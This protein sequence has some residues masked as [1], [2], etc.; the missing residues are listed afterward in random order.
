MGLELED[1]DGGQKSCPGV[2]ERS[3]V[4]IDQRPQM[5]ET[6]GRRHTLDEHLE[7]LGPLLVLLL[8]LVVGNQSGDHVGDRGLVDDLGGEQPFQSGHRFRAH[9]LH[10]DRF[11]VGGPGPI[12]IHQRGLV[13][14]GQPEDRGQGIGAQPIVDLLADDL[15]HRPHVAGGLRDPG[16]RPERLGVAGIVLENVAQRARGSDEVLELLLLGAS[17][18]EA[19]LGLLAAVLEPGLAP[20]PDLDQ[21]GPF[22]ALFQDAG[23]RAFGLLVVGQDRQDLLRAASRLLDPAEAGDVHPQQPA[24]HVHLLLLVRDPGRQ[25]SGQELGVGRPL[26]RVA[27]QPLEIA[28]HPEIARGQGV[29]P[30]APLERHRA[31]AQ[32]FLADHARVGEQ[33]K[34]FWHGERRQV[35]VDGS[36]CRAD[37][38]APIS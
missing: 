28:G 10:V 11:E 32:L 34:T 31:R 14:L 26:V 7:C 37:S 36:S 27:C 22:L 33:A 18:P 9:R 23:Q 8:E 12:G 30:G 24:Q 15:G 35:R 3:G 21:S 25:T 19:Q 13:Q 20:A 5:T 1:A 4:Q 29:R 38:P 16:Q 17:D 6:I 2:I